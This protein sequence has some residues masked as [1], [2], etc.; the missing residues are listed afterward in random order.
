MTSLQGLKAQVAY[1][2]PVALRE[3]GEL[4]LNGPYQNL[5]SNSSLA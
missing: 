3:E 4:W 5:N 1:S 2:F